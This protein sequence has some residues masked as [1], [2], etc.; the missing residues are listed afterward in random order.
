MNM[1]RSNH[2]YNA[3]S[4]GY[5]DGRVCCVGMVQV[6]DGRVL[7]SN[8]LWTTDNGLPAYHDQ[9]VARIPSFVERTDV[10]LDGGRAY[11]DSIRLGFDK[12]AAAAPAP[13]ASF[14]KGAQ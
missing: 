1:E 5:A 6:V 4:I 7:R 11:V 3:T 10:V 9:W 2:T 14:S 8:G 12:A 13:V